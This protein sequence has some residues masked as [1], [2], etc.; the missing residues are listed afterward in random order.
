MTK[1]RKKD[2]GSESSSVSLEKS[3]RTLITSLVHQ[4]PVTQREKQDL[5]PRTERTQLLGRRIRSPGTQGDP[6]TQGGP[7]T[8][9]G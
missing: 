2:R 1:S 9:G 7:G 3:S 8:E 4:H 6:G 5:Q